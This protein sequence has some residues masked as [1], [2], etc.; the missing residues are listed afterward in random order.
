MQLQFPTNA[1]E[2]HYGRNDSVA[3]LHK[4]DTAIML[5]PHNK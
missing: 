5:F 2:G 1:A 3:T 4:H